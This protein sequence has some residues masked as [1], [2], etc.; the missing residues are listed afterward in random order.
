MFENIGLYSYVPV[1]GDLYDIEHGTKKMLNPNLGFMDRAL[2]AGQAALGVGGLATLGVGSVGK[3]VAKGA[4]K[5]G[6]KYIAK[7]GAKKAM[8]KAAQEAAIRSG[9]NPLMVK[10]SAYFANKP[11]EKAVKLAERNKSLQNFIDSYPFFGKAT[12]IPYG[13][14][15]AGRIGYNLIKGNRI[16]GSRDITQNNNSN[17]STEA[18]VNGQRINNGNAYIGSGGSLGQL[19]PQQIQS[20]INSTKNN[21]GNAVSTT[22]DPRAL[23]YDYMI[24]QQAMQPYRDELNNYIRDYQRYSDWSYNQDKYL[25]LLS[26]LSGSQGLRDMIGKHTAMGDE[27]KLAGLKKVQGEDLKNVGEG[28]DKLIGNVALAK[29]LGLPLDAVN[30][31]D[32]MIKFAVY[33][34]MNDDKLENALIKQ[35]ALITSRFELMQAQER[36]KAA[37]RTRNSRAV[38]NAQNEV[39]HWNAINRQ[40]ENGADPQEAVNWGNKTFGT[41]FTVPPTTSLNS[42]GKILPM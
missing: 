28:Y 9:K 36:L 2:G 10:A 25:A 7:Y 5:G 37:L 31:S 42:G 18:N 13:A 20:T 14:I 19:T 17:E 39:K 26:S 41:N 23:Y 6:A 12:I 30:A 24:K 3:S 35:Q 32:D 4:I 29:Y 16:D 40:I 33:K 15:K 38:S 11:Y 22:G 27:E 1:V 21:N 8:N 34:D